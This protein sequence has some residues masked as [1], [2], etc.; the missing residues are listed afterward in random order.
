MRSSSSVYCP[1]CL[2]LLLLFFVF[3]VLL[4]KLFFV[5]FI[6]FFVFFVLLFIM[7]DGGDMN[8]YFVVLLVKL[9]GFMISDG[10]SAADDDDVDDDVL[11]SEM[12]VVFVISSLNFIRLGAGIN[13]VNCDVKMFC[14]SFL[15]LFFVFF[16]LL[17]GNICCCDG[18]VKTV[19]MDS[20]CC[21]NDESIIGCCDGENAFMI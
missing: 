15:C 10:N 17:F 4:F 5:L 12:C 3:F 18:C 8:E 1:L 16:V 20:D 2:L 13:D 21:V 9:F 7:M 6:I 19:G 11:L 14:G